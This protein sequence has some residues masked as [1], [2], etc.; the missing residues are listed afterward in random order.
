MH[1]EIFTGEEISAFIQQSCQR[2]KEL[3]AS[4]KMLLK[5]EAGARLIQPGAA[6]GFLG[7]VC[8]QKVGGYRKKTGA[9]QSG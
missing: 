6:S 3:P 2:D 4:W 1:L 8:T 5:V 9:I 7:H